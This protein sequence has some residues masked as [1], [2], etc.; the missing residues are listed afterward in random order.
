MERSRR[1]M[2]EV[3]SPNCTGLGETLDHLTPRSVAKLLGWKTRQLNH[4]ANL[5][6][7]CRPCHILKDRPT[8]L[9]KLQVK[10]QLRGGELKLGEHI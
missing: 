6:P 2:A 1:C 10:Y 8:P 5:I 3:R 7:M 4:P 9:V